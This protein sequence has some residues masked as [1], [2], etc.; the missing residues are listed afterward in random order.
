M[1]KKAVDIF[2]MTQK[3]SQIAIHGCPK[4]I[5][6]FLQANSNAV[7]PTQLIIENTKN[8]LLPYV[9]GLWLGSVRDAEKLVSGI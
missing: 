7:I 6:T 3:M 4:S 8:V 1:L 9:F 2:V 5:A